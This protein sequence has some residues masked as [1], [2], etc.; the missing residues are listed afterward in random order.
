MLVLHKITWI[1]WKIIFSNVFLRSIIDYFFLNIFFTTKNTF[2][3]LEEENIIKNIRNIFKLK[4]ELNYTALKDVTKDRK[5]T[6][7]KNFFEHEEEEHYYKPVRVNHFW[8]LLNTNILYW[9][10]K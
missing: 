9:T 2:L 5:F 10:R 8:S 6:D 3:T 4:N 1:F 7:I